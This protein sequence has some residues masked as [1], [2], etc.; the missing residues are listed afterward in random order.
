MGQPGRPVRVIA[1]ARSRAAL[2]MHGAVDWL[3]RRGASV[4]LTARDG[5]GSQILRERPP[6]LLGSVGPEDVVYA[7]GAPA[8]V[9]A[10]RRRAL[11]ADATFYADPFF[12]ASSQRNWRDWAA[13]ALRGA[14]SLRQVSDSEPPQRQM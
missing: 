11:E 3:R 9:D 8:Q 10:T 6:E 4:T 2:Y 7:A 14:Q 5:D 13:F 12:A 1:G